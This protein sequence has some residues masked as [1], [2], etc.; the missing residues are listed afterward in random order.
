MVGEASRYLGAVA[1]LLVAA[2]HGQ[3]YYDAYFSA[4]PTIGTLFLLNVIGAGA[5]GLVLLAPVGLL[6]V[7]LADAILVLGALAGIAVAA[8]S[9]AALLISEYR[10]L[11]GFM[12]SGYRL[13]I[14]LSLLFEG[15]ATL[16]LVVFVVALVLGRRSAGRA[17]GTYF[18]GRSALLF[19]S[20]RILRS[21][22]KE[23]PDEDPSLH[24]HA[25][26]LR[27]ERPRCPGCTGGAGERERLV[28]AREGRLEPEHAGGHADGRRQLPRDGKSE[29][30]PAHQSLAAELPAPRLRADRLKELPPDH[31]GGP[32]AGPPSRVGR[33]RS[34][35]ACDGLRRRG[36]AAA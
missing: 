9:F 12:E 5:A 31:Q 29:E 11:F 35:R 2:V 25:R 30:Q 15:L 26:R 1:L 19:P 3:Q 7:R 23:I 4:V 20:G 33:L 36:D 14:V 13:A 8:G 32:V 16:L 34:A 21:K 27:R 24:R 28:R 17:P 18:R 22:S 6:R 10:P